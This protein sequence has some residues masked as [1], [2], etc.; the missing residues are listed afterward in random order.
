[1]N[2]LC[3]YLLNPSRYFVQLQTQDAPPLGSIIWPA[4]RNTFLWNEGPYY[5]TSNFF[6]DAFWICKTVNTGC[7]YIHSKRKKVILEL[8]SNQLDHGTGVHYCKGM[9]DRH[10]GVLGNTLPWEHQLDRIGHS[11]RML[12]L[13]LI[14]NFQLAWSKMKYKSLKHWICILTET[15]WR[16]EKEYHNC[17]IRS[18]LSGYWVRTTTLG[19]CMSIAVHR[20]FIFK[21][22]DGLGQF[23]WAWHNA[24]VP[25]MIHIHELVLGCS[26]A[27]D[28]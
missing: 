19:N 22:C 6:S 13:P 2:C 4:A 11:Q 7:Y 12:P 27:Q 26:G 21:V 3:W 25:G 24:Y 15:C 28:H 16:R 5:Q 20:T 17:P 10:F 18:F 14:F 1:M 9:N 23:V 8:L